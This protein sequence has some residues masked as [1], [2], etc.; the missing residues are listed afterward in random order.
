VDPLF[1]SHLVVKEFHG[2]KRMTVFITR[3]TIGPG[4]T[5]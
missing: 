4:Y 3:S 1:P 5:C 2:T